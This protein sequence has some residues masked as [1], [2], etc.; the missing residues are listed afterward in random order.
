MVKL[1]DLFN[2]RKETDETVL[3]NTPT[4]MTTDI[5]KKVFKD[6]LVMDV[7]DDSQMVLTTQALCKCTECKE[8]KCVKRILVDYK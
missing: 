1:R 5:K 7:V 4:K 2:E 8:C 3:S 6:K